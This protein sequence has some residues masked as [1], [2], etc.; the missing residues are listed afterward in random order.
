MNKYGQR[1]L[2]E[3]DLVC[4]KTGISEVN[5]QGEYANIPFSLIL[6]FP[7]FSGEINDLKNIWKKP[8]SIE[9]Y[10]NGI[11]PLFTPIISQAS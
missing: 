3:N 6:P 8:T 9:L 11:Q 4:N 5:L 1:G 10:G 7:S 2:Q